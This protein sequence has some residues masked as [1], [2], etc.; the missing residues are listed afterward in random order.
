MGSAGSRSQPVLPAGHR[1]DPHERRED[2]LERSRR[3]LGAGA[4]PQLPGA[5]RVVADSWGRSVLGGLDPERLLAPVPLDAA[6]V[7]SLRREHPLRLVLPAVRRLLLEQPLGVPVLVAL[8]DQ[9]GHL[10]WVEGDSSLRA[11]AEEMR[12]VEGARWSEDAAGTNAPGTALHLGRPVRVVAGEHYACA[13]ARWS[14]S[15]APLRDPG[16]GRL[17]GV[18]DVT[19]GDE[20]GRQ[21]ALDLVQAVAAVAEAELRVRALTAPAAGSGLLLPGGA[22]PAA[23]RAPARLRVLGRAGALLEPPGAAGP[24]AASGAAGLGLRHG[25]LLLLLAARPEGWG[26]AELAVALAEEDLAPVTVRAELTRLRAVLERATAGRLGVGTRPYRLSGAVE[27]DALAVRR[28]LRAGRVAAALAL[29]AGPVLPRSVAPGVVELREELTLGL[30]TAVLVSRDPALLL[31]WGR[32][33]AGRD[34][35]EVW[36]RLLRCAAPGDP[37]RGEARARL[38]RLRG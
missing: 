27:C 10:L 13:V 29:H 31:Q 22:A 21:R 34:D 17:L 35:E 18:L 38:E 20:L 5:R 32:S 25:E 26:A 23:T 8:S 30:R 28:E 16:T 19:G 4:R 24:P 1:A 3:C 2:W 36:E 14:C 11:A 6:D 37:A 9:D 12:F 15:A 7:R 33:V